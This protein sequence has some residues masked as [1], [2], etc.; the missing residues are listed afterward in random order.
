MFHRGQAF[1]ELKGF[2]KKIIPLEVGLGLAAGNY[3]AITLVKSLICCMMK[4]EEQESVVVFRPHDDK[5]GNPVAIIVEDNYETESITRWT[6]C[7]CVSWKS[8]IS[9]QIFSSE[10]Y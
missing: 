7:C 1:N 3:V 2:I 5:N 8:I 9:R 10:L 6:V 4:C